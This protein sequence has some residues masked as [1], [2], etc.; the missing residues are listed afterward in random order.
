MMLY[1]YNCGCS[2]RDEAESYADY[3]ANC[4]GRHWF[5]TWD[6][7]DRSNYHCDGKKRKEQLPEREVSPSPIVERKL[8]RIGGGDSDIAVANVVKDKMHKHYDYAVG[9]EITSRSQKKRVYDENDLIMVSA[10]EE[11]KDKDKPRKTGFCSSYGGQKNHQSSAE[12][13][14]A[15]T[16]DGRQVI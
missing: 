2:L 10:N 12:R 11:Y 1:C 14:G 7:I 13:G 4:R 6:E 3:C 9:A 16:K 8:S 5:V 15:R